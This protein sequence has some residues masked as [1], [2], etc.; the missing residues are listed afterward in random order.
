MPSPMEQALI[1]LVPTLNSLP[2]ELIDLSTS[3]LAQSRNKAASLKP[4]E[5]I[6]RTYACAHI[7]VERL[8]NR[9]DIDKV[10]ARP[11]V[12]PRIYKKLYGYLDA[13]LSVPATPRTN[14]LKDVGTVG[15]PGSGRGRR[16]ALGTPVGTP[17]K[18]PAK[19]VRSAGVTPLKTPISAAKSVGSV[20]A[21]G[22]RTRSAAK[23][24]EEEVVIADSEED[25]QK[26][27]VQEQ[28]KGYNLPTQVPP[29]VMS[30]CDALDGPQASTHVLAA[31]S[32]IL[33]LRG[34]NDAETKT[35]KQ[36]PRSSVKKRKRTSTS[37][38]E[39]PT[40]QE[41]DKAITPTSLPALLAAIAL[42]TTFTLRNTVIDGT[43]YAA[44]R[45]SAIQALDPHAPISAEVDAFLHASKTEGWLELPWF[46]AVKAAATTIAIPEA[47][48]PKKNKPPAKTPL[49]RKEKHAPRP[50][51][52]DLDMD[53]VME[54]AD[55]E[56]EEEDADKPGA[57]LR[58]GLGTMFQDSVDWLSMDRRKEYRAWK[59]DILQRCAEIESRA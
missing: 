53:T 14:R 30:V 48:T 39:E 57:G 6:G 56:A 49:H 10:V 15:T 17:S 50:A 23:A 58:S 7:A 8:R 5:E 44:A 27:I 55:A 19:S 29:L 43:A 37:A 22:R 46:T 34:Y 4:D 31:L 47:Q 51:A 41:D 9:L 1:T 52:K 12:A 18:T 54:D 32:A 2:Q 26:Q 40:S 45:S 38:E 59:R 16:S 24:P 28:E 21:S 20:T 25:I 36:T 3:L 13:A 35:N 33:Q 11:P 42:I